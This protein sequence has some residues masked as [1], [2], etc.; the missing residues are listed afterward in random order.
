MGHSPSRKIHWTKLE[1]L[2]MSDF[3]TAIKELSEIDREHAVLLAE[4]VISVFKTWFIQREGVRLSNVGTLQVK[5][6]KARPG[7]NPRT[8]EAHQINERYSVTLS[9]TGLKTPNGKTALIKKLSD[10]F[11]DHPKATI[12]NAVSAISLF[13][14]NVEQGEHRIEIRGFGVFYPS[15]VSPKK[16]FNA[17]YKKDFISEKKIKIGFK[18]SPVLLKKVNA[19]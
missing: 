8:G 19:N 5:H 9:Q 4:G 15:I 6:K 13:I 18:C 16:G 2:T 3:T 7:R 14:K 12:Y 17:I 1:T 10:M 11:P